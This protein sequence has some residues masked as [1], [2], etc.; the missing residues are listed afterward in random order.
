MTF[1]NNPDIIKNILYNDSHDLEIRIN[2]HKK[3]SESKLNWDEWVIN[4]LPEKNFQRILDLGCGNGRFIFSLLKRNIGNS[5]LGIDISESNIQSA[6]SELSKIIDAD[7]SFISGDVETIEKKLS[8]YD[9]IMCNHMLWHIKNISG[10][11]TKI[12]SKLEP[13]GIFLATTNAPDY[14][15]RMYDL[16]LNLAKILDFPENI[17]NQNFRNESF[18]LDN[19]DAILSNHFNKVK[20][21]FLKDKLIF[22][23]PEPFIKYFLTFLKAQMKIYNEIKEELWVRLINQMTEFVISEIQSKGKFE[24]E[25]I[26]GVFLAY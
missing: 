12:K 17:L 1:L 24:I 20:K 4:L 22:L 19:G 2:T 10:F 6:N 8:N 3:F 23:N 16:Y 26:S 14:M 9:L 7:V 13:E 5:F 11:L 21:Y 18:S 25:K 15:M